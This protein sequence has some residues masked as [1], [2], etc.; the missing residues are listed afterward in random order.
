MSI[1]AQRTVPSAGIVQDWALQLPWR[2]PSSRTGT[3]QL[4]GRPPYDPI[5]YFSRKDIK[6]NAKVTDDFD[7]SKFQDSVIRRRAAAGHC[8]T[9]VVCRLWVRG[10]A[11]NA[12][13]LMTQPDLTKGARDLADVAAALTHVRADTPDWKWEHDVA[14]LEMADRVIELRPKGNRLYEPMQTKGDSGVA[15]ATLRTDMRRFPAEGR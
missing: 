4:G 14:K 8:R 9:W 6:N 13:R 12:L 2:C 10:S 15:N 5:A 1:R 3:Y 11:K 7:R